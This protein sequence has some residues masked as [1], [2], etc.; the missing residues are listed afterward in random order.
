M[1]ILLVDPSLDVL[2]AVTA[3]LEAAHHE[4]CAFA[5]EHEALR[6]LAQDP[7][8]D[9]LLTSVELG[10]ISG[11]EMCQRA[12]RVAG[13]R[14][15]L[16]IIVMSDDSARQKLVAALDSGA[17][18]FI[19]MPPALDE[20]YARL[21]TGERLV[22]MQRDLIQLASLDSLTG[23]FNRRAFFL[24]SEEICRTAAS[25]GEP[26]AAIMLDLD[27]F[28]AINDTYGHDIGDAALKAVAAEIA[29]VDDAVFG[30]LG[31]EEFGLIL[32]QC[33]LDEATEIAEG[34][35]AVIAGLAF[36]APHGTISLSCSFGV[37]TF[38]P[39]ESVDALLKR[40]DLALYDAKRLGRDR[41]VV[42]NGDE[43]RARAGSV[44][45]RDLPPG[46]RAAE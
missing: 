19:G 17:D 9:A 41:V 28:K 12:R 1:R 22:G 35:R 40:A 45:R 23:A 36:A 44:I 5:D 30:R 42:F 18:D 7:R 34:L 46:E 38:T 6:C 20:L 14:R 3:L 25:T 11:L 26:V 27:H 13:D 37:A 39:G 24:A 43:R 33:S 31:G 10:T 15:P 8:I 4:V 21:R 29:H 16:Y 32:D 2:D